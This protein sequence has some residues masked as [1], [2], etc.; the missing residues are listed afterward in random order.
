M[1]LDK[2]HDMYNNVHMQSIGITKAREKLP[3]LMEDVYFK[4][5]TFLLTRRGIPMAKLTAVQDNKPKKPK[6]TAEQRRKAIEEVAG[7][8]KD[9]WPG[10]S[11]REVVEIL[12]EQGWKSHAR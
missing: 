4:S 2:S 3:D 7:L 1:L 9:R 10:K 6:Y 11:S 8:W 5:K 12:R